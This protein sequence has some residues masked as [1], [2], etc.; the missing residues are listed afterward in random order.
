MKRAVCS[1]TNGIRVCVTC[2]KTDRGGTICRGKDPQRT[3][4]AETAGAGGRG[5]LRVAAGREQTRARTDLVLLVI[6]VGE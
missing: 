6:H 3:P 2:R 5:A 4:R 1:G